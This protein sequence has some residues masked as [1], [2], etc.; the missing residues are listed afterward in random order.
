MKVYRGKLNWLIYAVNETCTFVFPKGFAVGDPVYTAYQ[1]TE[2]SSGA[3]KVN[4]FVEGYVNMDFVVDGK[5]TIRFHEEN[6]YHFDATIS[7][8]EKSIVVTMRND[9]HGSVEKP[10]TLDLAMTSDTSAL[11]LYMGKYTEHPF[12]DNEM[13]MVIGSPN[14]SSGNSIGVFWQW[15]KQSGGKEKVPQTYTG[16]V[17]DFHQDTSGIKFDFNKDS[18]YYKFSMNVDN[19]LKNMKLRIATQPSLLPNKPDIALTLQKSTE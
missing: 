8:D 15:T 14:F 18:N 4:N 9:P 16:T 3:K 11:V 12:A 13:I 10:T 2:N 5:R 1:W 19:S 6:Y 7:S 17:T